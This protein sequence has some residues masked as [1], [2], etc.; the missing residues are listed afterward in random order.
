[1]PDF[2]LENKVLALLG[3]LWAKNYHSSDTCLT[4]VE[5]NLDLYGQARIDLQELIDCADRHTVPL[6]HT[7]LWVPL[8]VREQDA[9]E[10]PLHTW[11][12]LPPDLK[13]LPLLMNRITA[14]SLVWHAGIDYDLWPDGVC[15]AIIFKKDP[16]EEPLLPTVGENGAREVTF[17]GYAGK[18]DRKY[19]WRRLGR[20]LDLEKSTSRAYKDLL[21]TI[22]DLMAH[23]TNFA[24]FEALVNVVL[25]APVA[26]QD[27]E[28]VE[29]LYFDARGP[30]VATD[31]QTYRIPEGLSDRVLRDQR[32]RRGEPVV[33][34]AKITKTAPATVIISAPQEKFDVEL[35]KRMLPPDAELIFN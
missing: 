2:H 32:L 18:F 4:T 12:P 22:F 31:V 28:V 23:G 34:L 35:L 13:E 6:Y 11:Y 3:A 19:L 5:A 15:P 8:T 7:E 10:G 1:M 33:K 16:F 14:P 25:G 9:N 26:Q 27:G 30:F 21:N 20:L 29:G 24:T 17:W